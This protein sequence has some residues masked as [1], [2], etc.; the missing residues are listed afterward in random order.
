MCDSRGVVR[1]GDPSLE[2]NPYKA[3]YAAQTE[4]ETLEQA[5]VDADVFIGVSVAGA[6]TRAMVESMAPRPNT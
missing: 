1:V 5:L 6:V 4:L 2:K 3:R